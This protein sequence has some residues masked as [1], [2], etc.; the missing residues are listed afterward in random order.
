MVLV[1]VVAAAPEREA[2][3]TATHQYDGDIG[4]VVTTMKLKQVR[5]DKC[6]SRWWRYGYFS[7]GELLLL[8]L[9]TGVCGF[10]CGRWGPGEFQL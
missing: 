3:S 6:H 1:V 8:L 5:L 4:L 9:D 7:G 2:R 10:V